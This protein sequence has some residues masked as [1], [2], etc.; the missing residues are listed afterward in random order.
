MRLRV[1]VVS[2]ISLDRRKWELASCEECRVIL[3]CKLRC[4]WPWS[5][6]F[7]A[8][9]GSRLMTSFRPFSHT[10]RQLIHNPLELQLKSDQAVF[11]CFE[12]L[13]G[14]TRPRRTVGLSTVV[15]TIRNWHY[16]NHINSFSS[17]VI[18]YVH[19]WIEEKPVGLYYMTWGMKWMLN[20]RSRNRIAP[21]I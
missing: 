15:A 11:T 5:C 21:W 18:Y 20:R 3:E 1:D 6:W 19:L 16:N 9:H 2:G 10:K 12:Q 17:H 4:Q 13:F 7:V 14:L 8:G